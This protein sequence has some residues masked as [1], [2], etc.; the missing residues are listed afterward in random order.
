MNCT[1]QKRNS[2][3]SQETRTDRITT[4]ACL[5]C[6]HIFI[7]IQDESVHNSSVSTLRHFHF[8]RLFERNG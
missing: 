4:L 5:G 6:S 1:L 3:I 2:H 7:Q 8:G